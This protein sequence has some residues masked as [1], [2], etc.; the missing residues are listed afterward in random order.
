MNGRTQ[1]GLRLSP[2]WR[3]AL[4]AVALVG[5]RHSDALVPVEGTL[6]LDD[7]PL[8]GATVFLIPDGLAGQSAWGTVQQDG[9]FRL[10]TSDRNGAGPGDYRAIVGVLVPERPEGDAAKEEMSSRQK[11]KAPMFVGG[12]VVPPLYS[13]ASTT[14]LRCTVPVQGK[15]A[16]QLHSTDR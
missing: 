4:I 9:S 16:L 6:T 2:W 7:R 11:A 5:C 15:L 1:Y 8:G 3:L 10:K 13:N 14:P 12:L